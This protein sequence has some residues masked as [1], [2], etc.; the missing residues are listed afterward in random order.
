MKSLST[1][2]HIRIVFM[3]MAFVLAITW[4]ANSAHA[5]EAVGS[6]LSIAPSGQI[7]VKGARVVGVSGSTIIAETGWG[8]AK[9]TWSIQ[10]TGSTKFT[11]DL[12]STATVAKVAKGHTI[13]FTGMLNG[14][15]AKPTVIANAVKD[16]ELVQDSVSILGIVESVDAEENTFILRTQG[17][18]T[19]VSLT[20]GT[21]MSRN[22]GYT[23]IYD[24]EVGDSTRATGTLD[25]TTGVLRAERI[26]VKEAQEEPV[27]Q[28]A[29]RESML[30]SIM[31][32]LRGSRGI[33]TVR[34]R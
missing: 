13:S 21:L 1:A 24:I 32:W 18:T 6:S 2:W 29:P 30:A 15:L 22:G 28:S 10:T 34:D 8:E 3:V 11:P 20:G 25:T 27:V 4:G 7:I 9:M 19:T 17:G 5:E 33:L 31:T 23:D 12:G 14:S 26:S 16:S